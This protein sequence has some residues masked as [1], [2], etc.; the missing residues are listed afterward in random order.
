M[1]KLTL[2]AI[3]SALLS[4]AVAVKNAVLS[5]KGAVWGGIFT[6][7]IAVLW[8][9]RA[10]TD[11]ANNRQTAALDQKEKEIRNK[12]AIIEADALQIKATAKA[13]TE[14]Q[15]SRLN[16]AG[17]EVDPVERRRK[18]AELLNSL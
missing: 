4:A 13:V 9:V 11:A 6:G 18:L 10:F 17:A 14:A 8:I 12:M 7:A 16:E 1:I 15:L 5:V 3:K 2:A